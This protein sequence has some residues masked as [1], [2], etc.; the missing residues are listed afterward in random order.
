MWR[1]NLE[2]ICH[3]E[4]EVAMFHV[5]SFGIILFFTSNFYFCSFEP[6]CNLYS[7]PMAMVSIGIPMTTALSI[8]SCFLVNMTFHLDP[9]NIF[10]S[11]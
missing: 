11:R 4:I 10:G 9:S 7:L 1:S 8:P 6:L 3:G 5:L 2:E